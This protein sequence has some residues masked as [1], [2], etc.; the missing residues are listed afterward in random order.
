[1]RATPLIGIRWAVA[2]IALQLSACAMQPRV[3]DAAP[4]DR[5][6][7]MLQA[8]HSQ[9]EAGDWLVIRGVHATDNAVASLSNQPLSHAAVLD[10][11]RG[12]VIEAEGVGVHETPIADFVAKSRRL[13]L[14]KPEAA[15]AATRPAAIARARG[16]VG[17]GYDFLGLAGV[18]VRDRYY[19]TELALTIYPLTRGSDPLPAVVPPGQLWHWG[20]IAFD[21]GPVSTPRE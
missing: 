13:L 11:E 18:N 19:C 17:K 7:A 14:I 12:V 3:H 5:Q 1:M 2:A 6:A 8:I 20:T 21:S 4:D 15:T 9:G 10:P 16:L